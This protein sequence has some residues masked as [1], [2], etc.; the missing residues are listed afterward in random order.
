M[1]FIELLADSITDV[2]TTG[3]NDSTNALG[4]SIQCKDYLFPKSNTLV[5]I[6]LLQEGA[7]TVW[8]DD[9]IRGRIRIRR[10]RKTEEREVGCSLLRGYILGNRLVGE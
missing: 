2:W 6:Y 4:F 1:D 5:E 10:I 9:H 3:G 7:T 8:M